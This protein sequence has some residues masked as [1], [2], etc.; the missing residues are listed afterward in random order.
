MVMTYWDKTNACLVTEAIHFA[1]FFAV[2]EAVVVLHA[3]EFCPAVALGTVLEH[4]ELIGSHTTG[5]DVTHFATLNEITV[6]G[7]HR[8]ANEFKDEECLRKT[9]PKLTIEKISIAIEHRV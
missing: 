3:D 1:L 7:G 5:S 2:E 6:R 9:C 8:L 4:A